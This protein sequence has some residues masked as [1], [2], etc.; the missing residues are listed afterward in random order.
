M[1]QSRA[2]TWAPTLSSSWTIGLLQ[3]ASL[4]K[5]SSR[6]ESSG[7]DTKYVFG[8]WKY[9]LQQLY[10]K[11]GAKSYW[12]K[13]WYCYDGWYVL[14]TL[15]T[16]L[17]QQSLFKIYYCSRLIKTKQA[18]SGI[19]LYQMCGYINVMYRYIYLREKMVKSK[20]L[21]SETS[22]ELWFWQERS[23]GWNAIK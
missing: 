21:H 12:R 5:R 2:C 3:K 22:E 17:V 6:A 10:N 11:L 1:G 8:E 13:S 19:L 14:E 9:S 16:K 15:K 7:L 4:Q 23:W 20:K 18:S